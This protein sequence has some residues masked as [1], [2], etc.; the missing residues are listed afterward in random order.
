LTVL[1][2]SDDDHRTQPRAVQSG[3]TATHLMFDDV[4]AQVVYLGQENVVPAIVEFVNDN[5]VQLLLSVT[6][7]MGFLQSLFKG[8]I[9]RQLA[10]HT[11][12]PLMVFRA[13]E[14]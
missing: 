12:V 1:N 9:T 3:V 5:D 11:T 6:H 2:V 14:N 13:I 7:K 10:F 8:S 4:E